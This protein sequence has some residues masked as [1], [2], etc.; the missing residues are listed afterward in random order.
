MQAE[1]DLSNRRIEKA[2]ECL[3]AANLLLDAGQYDGAINR[4]YYCVFHA[5]RSVLALEGVDF[6]RHSAVIAH[7]RKNYIK[8]GKFEPS[9]SDII[10]KIFDLR[11]ES[12]YEDYSEIS[13]QEV[14]EQIENA[15]YFLG[16]V[17][18]YL[19]SASDDSS[20]KAKK[21]SFEM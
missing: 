19:S 13:K 21:P 6:N 7:F 20:G 17:K 14:I 16:Q 18:E 2:G 15:E 3:D 1:K 5:I 11:G 8:T 10:G 4:S 9:V 12:D